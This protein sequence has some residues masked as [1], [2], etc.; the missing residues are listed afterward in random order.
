MKNLAYKCE[1]FVNVTQNFKGISKKKNVLQAFLE[2]MNYL[3]KFSPNK[4]EVC[5]SQR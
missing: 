5:D 1:I 2:G 4:A 3:S